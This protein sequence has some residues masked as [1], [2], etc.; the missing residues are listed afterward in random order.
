MTSER[1]RRV[2]QE[3]DALAWLLDDTFRI[4]GTDRRIGLEAIIGFVPGIGDA[5]SGLV[6]V[7]LIG[8]GVRLRLPTIVVVR[9]V[10]NTLLDF[11]VGAIPVLG[12]LFD[13]VYKSN[14]R[15]AQLVRTYARDPGAP[16]RQ[17]WLFVGGVAL[18]LVGLLWLILAGLAWLLEAI[19][20]AFR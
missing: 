14:A 15:N 5:I 19:V 12:D 18:V 9:M 8:R 13:L 1:A 16:T 11:T 7:Y 4:P 6:G 20:G 17:H 10:F 3:L 2:E